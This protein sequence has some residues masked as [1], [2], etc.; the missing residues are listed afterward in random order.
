[1]PKISDEGHDQTIN[2]SHAIIIIYG[3][4]ARDLHKSVWRCFNHCYVNVE[5]VPTWIFT[6]FCTEGYLCHDQNHALKVDFVLDKNEQYSNFQELTHPKHHTGKIILVMINSGL[7]KYEY[8]RKLLPQRFHW[9]L[10]CTASP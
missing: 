6:A 4:V 9:L 10:D 7:Q 1:M 3:F 8:C 5:Q 2:V